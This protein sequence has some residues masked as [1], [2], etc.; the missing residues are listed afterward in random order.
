MKIKV[1]LRIGKNIQ[2]D[3]R[4]TPTYVASYFGDVKILRILVDA[5]ADVN[6][7]DT[8]GATPAYVASDIGNVE[9]LRW[10]HQMTSKK[11][12]MPSLSKHMLTTNT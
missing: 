2:V 10:C 9:V 12:F 3:I 11:R 1:H 8:K 6:K 5:F 7:A 4:R